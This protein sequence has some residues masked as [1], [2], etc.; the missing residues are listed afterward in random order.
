[1]T[2]VTD[3]HHAQRFPGKP[4][5]IVTRR[6]MPAVEARMRELFDV[7]LNA[8]DLPFD[9]A[10]LIAAADQAGIAI[11]AISPFVSTKCSGE[12]TSSSQGIPSK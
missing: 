4:R 6:L 11:E 5:V 7:Q 12:P 1:M 9:R 8:D 10:A 2:V 3:A